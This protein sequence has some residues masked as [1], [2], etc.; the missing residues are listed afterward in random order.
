ML[1]LFSIRNSHL[2][3][4]VKK[5]G[6]YGLIGKQQKCQATKVTKLQGSLK[7]QD[8]LNKISEYLRDQ[9]E[10]LVTLLCFFADHDN[11]ST[12][13]YMQILRA[14]FNNEKAFQGIVDKLK[15]VEDAR[16]HKDDPIYLQTMTETLHNLKHYEKK[17]VGDGQQFD[18][19]A[20]LSNRELM[21][22]TVPYN[23]IAL[24]SKLDPS[25]QRRVVQVMMINAA[26]ATVKNGLVVAVY[27]FSNLMRV[28]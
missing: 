27:K 11:Q 12:Q 3:N 24:L 2:E 13:K 15:L 25:A 7:S 10:K 1:F 14:V 8:I 4:K 9:P 22:A 5:T 20:A 18:F 6:H 16:K 28:I 17:N 26:Y 23:I 19:Q 21:E